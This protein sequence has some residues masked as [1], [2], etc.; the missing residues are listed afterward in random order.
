M[1][2]IRQAL[3][4]GLG[5]S[6]R[7]AV[8]LLLS[9]GASVTGVD[10]Q[11]RV[12]AAQPLGKDGARILT[13]CTDLPG[14]AFDLA[15]VS[16]GI[17]EDH[18]WISALRERGIPCL[19]ELELGWSR[20]RGRVWAITG[21]NG[22][23]TLVKCCAESLARAGRNARIAGNYGIS[24]CEQVGRDPVAD[25]WVIEVSSFQMETADRFR[26][27]IGILLNV[28]PN[29]LDRHGSMDHYLEL[30]LRM[31]A[32]MG[33]KDVCVVPAPLAWACGESAVTFGPEESAD[34]RWAAGRVVQEGVSVA[35]FRGTVFDNDVT[36]PA[37]AALS[38]AFSSAKI[39]VAFAEEAARSFEPLPHRMQRA[40]MIRGV[41][42]I[43][44]SKA[45]NLAAL[46]ASLKMTSRPVRLIAGGQAKEKNFEEIKEVLAKRV[47][48]AY[49]IGRDSEKMS[50][51]WADAVPC[52]MCGD[53]ASAV[54]KAWSDAHEGE[55]ILLAPGCTS[56]DQFRN[57]AERGEKFMQL[58]AGLAK[59]TQDE[60]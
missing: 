47:Q 41:E 34:F 37:M 11:P 45:T 52:R 14:D 13:G 18:A 33:P 2:K 60:K 44:N 29:H 39:P 10:S 9:E 36:G 15:V 42:F 26:P 59:E 20:C 57:F 54:Q 19:S 43:N 3:V 6:G 7:G 31:F 4:L 28:L 46:E 12:D 51:A 5:E 30:K 48:T 50:L 38:A 16:P 56:Y 24:F 40:A 32:R 25:D 53:L 27:D 21:S 8:R 23:S 1:K 55:V 35:D 58:A 22:K 49:L 17:A